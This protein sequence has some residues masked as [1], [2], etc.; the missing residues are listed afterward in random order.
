MVLKLGWKPDDLLFGDQPPFDITQP[1]THDSKKEFLRERDT[2]LAVMD[3]LREIVQSLFY[4]ED[5]STSGHSEMAVRLGAAIDAK[6]RQSKSGM[7][8]QSAKDLARKNI[9][10]AGF[11][12][13]ALFVLVDMYSAYDQRLEDLNE[14]EA[15]FWNVGHR[16]PNYYA[17]TIAIRFARFYAGQTRTRPT[18]GTARDGGHP[19]TD[20]GR[21]LEEVFQI[22]GINADIRGPA[23]WALTQITDEDVNPPRTGLMGGLF[24]LGFPGS[25]RENALTELPVDPKARE[26][27]D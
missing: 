9:V 20:Y 4:S 11:S 25:L 13:T 14:Q 10:D 6:A 12:D 16:P 15:E 27:G 23:E 21:I 2:V 5:E 24:G 19:S 22:L 18:F 26:K 17:R 7:T 1:N 3:R 8:I